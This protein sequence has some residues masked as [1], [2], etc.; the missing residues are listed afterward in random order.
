MR[1]RAPGAI[2]GSLDPGGAIV[3]AGGDENTCDGDALENNATFV[4]AR[5]SRAFFDW[6]E[7]DN[8]VDGDRRNIRPLHNADAPNFHLASDRLR[9]RRDKPAAFGGKVRAIVGHQ[10]GTHR[11]A[12]EKRQ[13]KG[14]LAAAGC[15]SNQ[16]AM[17]AE[18]SDAGVN[19]MLPGHLRV[20]PPAAAR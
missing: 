12:V 13:K 10:V 19:R 2:Q 17:T 20:T 7:I 11:I 8:E 18:A 15:S 3:G 9:H 16:N 6:Q 14:R 4:L 1:N 5:Q